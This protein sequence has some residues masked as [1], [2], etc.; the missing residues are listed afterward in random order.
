MERRKHALALRMTVQIAPVKMWCLV[1]TRKADRP[2]KDVVPSAKA[3][4]N[5]FSYR[6]R[7]APKHVRD[8]WETVKR[9]SDVASRESFMASVMSVA[10]GDYSNVCVSSTTSVTHEKGE[11]S[12]KGWVS[13]KTVADSE[14]EAVVLAM[15]D[16]KT[17]QTRPHEKLPPGSA[18]AWPHNLQF[19]WEQKKDVS[20]TGTKD[21]VKMQGP[22]QEMDAEDA[23]VMFKAMD[24][25][26]SSS[27]LP[28]ASAAPQ[29]ARPAQA[30]Q[31]V[32]PEQLSQ[33]AKDALASIRKWHG[34]FDR[35][36]K[37]KGVQE[38]LGEECT[39]RGDEEEL[40]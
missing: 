36:K 17:I 25:G 31:E 18:V 22:S 4:Y 6:L 12:E 29:A 7:A 37:K 34:E 2:S 35:K 39:V 15:I 8:H 14:G 10:R 11:K 30:T 21:E 23:Q 5:Q 1:A 20:M 19:L 26:A 28:S 9:S 24:S 16:A 32:K 27:C 33:E 40:L 3:Q 13:F 38:H